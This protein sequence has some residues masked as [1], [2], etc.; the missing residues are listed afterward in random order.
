MQ[1]DARYVYQDGEFGVIGVPQNSPFGKKNY[2]LQAE[3]MM[4]RHFPDGYEVVRAEEVVEG[5]RMLDTQ[6]TNE[7]DTEPTIRA[8]D[9]MIKLGKLVQS[10]T[11]Q[12]KDT[13]PILECRII[14]KRKSPKDTPGSNGFTSVATIV[15]ALYIDPNEVTRCQAKQVIAAAGKDGKPGNPAL[16]TKPNVPNTTDPATKQASAK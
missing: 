1:P 16:A 7:L 5:Q 6:R 10:K 8:M 4:S 2:R 15:P 14:Y 9:Q 13:V 11:L 12:Q 3:E